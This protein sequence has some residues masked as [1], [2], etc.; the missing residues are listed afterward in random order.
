MQ[1]VTF[2]DGD[3]V[4]PGVLDGS[5]VVDLSAFA[6]SVLEIIARDPERRALPAAATGQRQPLTAM[7]LAAPIPTPAR[8]IYCV[9]KNYS[10]HAR[11][12]ERSGIDVTSA[13]Q[14][15]PKAP[16]IFTKAPSAVIGPEACIPGYL[17]PTDTVDY[18]GELGVIIGRGGRGI[19]KAGAMAHVYGYTIINDVTSRAQQQIHSQ[20]FLG[21]SID[22]F[23][24]MGP[25][26]VTADEIADPRWL[27]IETRVNGELR[28][29]A[30]VEDLIF[31]IPTLIETLSRGITLIPGDI[32]ATGTPEGVG[33]GFRPPRYL[34]TGD[35]VS[36]TIE[37]IGTLRNPVA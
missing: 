31:D 27:R 13:G 32:I 35:V 25:A 9:G 18:E 19:A 1:L 34:R 16:I 37:P 8:N 26:I 3:R 12:F 5:E 21:K 2:C 29:H 22:G 17:D 24:P 11:E 7:K 23:C 20:W 30:S 28:Q 36:V 4:L 10:A 33:I 15:I 6:G 14:D